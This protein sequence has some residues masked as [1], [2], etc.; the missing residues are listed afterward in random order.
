MN[1]YI[2]I[3]VGIHID[4]VSG[5]IEQCRYKIIAAAGLTVVIR[6]GDMDIV[7]IAV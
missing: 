2:F 7:I 3:L 6:D 4:E 5:R 1:T